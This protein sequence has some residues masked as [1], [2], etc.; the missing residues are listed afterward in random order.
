MS[1]SF[2]GMQLTTTS[3]SEVIVNGRRIDNLDTVTSG[4]REP[5]EIVRIEEPDGNGCH[6]NVTLN[7]NVKEL[8]FNNE[9]C[10]VKINGLVNTL[11]NKGA[12]S[13]FTID[14]P[15]ITLTGCGADQQ[16][17]KISGPVVTHRD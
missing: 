13:H 4:D 5:I 2:N 11:I 6:F 14:G 8:H 3:S 9:K 15:V 1:F 7:A 12:G 17:V 10:T 16:H